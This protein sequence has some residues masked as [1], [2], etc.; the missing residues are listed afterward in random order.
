V[1][2]ADKPWLIRELISFPFLPSP[3]AVI[4]AAL[5][6]L[7]MRESEVFADL[8]C[9]EGNVLVRAA[10]KLRVFCVGFEIDQRLLP[11]AKQN[12]ARAGVAEHVD[13]VYA[14]LFTVDL[15]RFRAIYVYPF[16]AI[17]DRIAH[18]IRSE[19]TKG[20]QVV[21]HDYV[22]PTFSPFTSHHVTIDE[23]HKHRVFL[24]IV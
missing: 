6:L 13:V 10:E 18:K 17:A 7:C 1:C 8:G 20:T 12:I 23:V 4:E 19:C 5:D 3:Q 21:V 14:D 16:P 2:V 15:S 9:G 11:Q 22:L 24:Y